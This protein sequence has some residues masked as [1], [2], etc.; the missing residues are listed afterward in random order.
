MRNASPLHAPLLRSFELWGRFAL[1][2][3]TMLMSAGEVIGR[4]TT[5]MAT[6]GIAPNAGERR[7]MHRMV[8]EKQ[9]A[10]VEGSLAAWGVWMHLSQ[11]SWLEAV[12]LTTRNGIALAPIIVGMNPINAV[13]RSHRYA[14]HATAR[15]MASA[16]RQWAAPLATQLKIA[17]AAIEPVRAQVAANRKRLAA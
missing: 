7:E 14:R 6:H 13:S 10:L 2:N 3:A 4:R 15:S 12:R 17:D 5:Q 16:S 8:E 1:D 9:S 11:S